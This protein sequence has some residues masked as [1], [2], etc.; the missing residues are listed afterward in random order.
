M[1]LESL[2][3][4]KSKWYLLFY[5]VN[6]YDG[7]LHHRYLETVSLFGMQ[8]LWKLSAPKSHIDVKTPYAKAKFS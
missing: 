6:E 3:S 2:D 1:P 7:K 4:L 5:Y 8:A